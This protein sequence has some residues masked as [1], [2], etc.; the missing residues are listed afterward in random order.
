[1]EEISKRLSQGE[2]LHSV[3]QDLQQSSSVEGV[4][5][6]EVQ[7]LTASNLDKVYPVVRKHY[8]NELSETE[9]KV[10]DEVAIRRL[11]QLKYTT[12]PNVHYKTGGN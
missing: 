7:S 4:S 6:N 2:D 9:A 1:M 11:R 8:L 12:R 10:V 5:E 3:L